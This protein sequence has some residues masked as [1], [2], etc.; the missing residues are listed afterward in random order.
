MAK[1]ITLLFLF[2]LLQGLIHPIFAAEPEAISKSISSSL[3]LNGATLSALWALPFLGMI[4]SI[5][6]FPLI[7]PKFWGDHY[8][9]VSFAWSAIVLIGLAISQGFGISLHSF[10]LVMFEQFLPFIFL[11]LSLFTITGGIKLRGELIGNP[12]LNTMILL[13]G[14]IISSWLGTTGAAVL[15]I[16]PLISAN[17]W[18]THKVHTIVF[19][20]FIVANIGGSLTPVGNPPLL[21]GFISKVPFFWPLSKLF[22][23]TAIACG[24]LLVTYFLLDSYF[25]KKET[26]KPVHKKK[27]TLSIEGGWNFLLLIG[28]IFA[29]L[30]S[31]QDWGIAFYVYHVPMP[32]SELVEIL[33]MLAITLI[34]LKITRKETRKANQF[35]WHPILEVGKIFAAIFVCMAPLIAM[36]RAGTEGPMKFIIDSLS[37]N[38]KPINGMYYWLSGGLSAFLDSAPAYLVFFN[39]AAA[40]A[41]AAGMAPHVFMTSV[42]PA[43]LIAITAGASFM[44]AI[45]YIGNAPNMMI[46][47]IAEEDGIK[48]PSF[49]GYM[50][51]SVSILVPLFILIQ[52]LFIS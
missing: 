34:S 27:K 11:L 38:G 17:L 21:M 1:K 48:M 36:L 14:A 41:A 3:E 20:T 51:W 29:V 13:I 35:Q 31:S 40:P 16:R 10:I 22:A 9:K 28:V 42:L 26:A 33:A 30:A 6:I 50:L 23:P 25:Y 45:T 19:F 12:R 2:V 52:L 7:L 8:G 24:I 43:T 32:L 15:L 47:A 18:R 5:A 37:A 46:K 44:G 49:F 4:L 39:T